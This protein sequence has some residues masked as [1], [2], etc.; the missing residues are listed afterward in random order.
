MKTLRA[1]SQGQAQDLSCGSGLSPALLKS[2]LQVKWIPKKDRGRGH[3]GGGF[4]HK[5]LAWQTWGPESDPQYLH[6]KPGTVLC[7]WNISSRTVETGGFW[8]SL[9]GELQASERP[10]S[11]KVFLR[12]NSWGC[13]PFSQTQ[14]R[15]VH[16][17]LYT[18]V[19][20]HTCICC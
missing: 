16:M 10:V 17:H 6:K 18:Y 13:H 9:T 7:T 11:I 12:A 3:W 5:L 20:T 2:F 1:A 19:H 4:V 14:T 15:T 8:S